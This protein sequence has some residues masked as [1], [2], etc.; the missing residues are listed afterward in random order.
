VAATI[1]V[2]PG[3]VRQPDSGSG[4]GEIGAVPEPCSAAI[5]LSVVSGLSFFAQGH[6]S[7]LFCNGWNS[8]QQLG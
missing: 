1:S 4:L 2:W 5:L 6:R 8:N 3:A 7:H